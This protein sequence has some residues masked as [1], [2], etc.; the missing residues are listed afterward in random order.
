M[1]NIITKYKGKHCEI[2][3]VGADITRDHIIPKWLERRFEYFQL[4]VYMVNNDQYLCRLHNGQKG[5][6]IDYRDERVRR[7]LRKFIKMIENK[8]RDVEAELKSERMKATLKVKR[9]EKLKKLGVGD[10]E[11]DKVKF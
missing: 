1:T 6:I 9:D 8:I 5:G 3:G 4:D 10:K 7:F 11:V 2:C